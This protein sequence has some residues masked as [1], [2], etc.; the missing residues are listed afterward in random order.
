MKICQ[1]LRSSLALLLVLAS[2][3]GMVPAVFAT[4]DRRQIT[5]YAD[6]LVAQM[7]QEEMFEMYGNE[8]DTFTDPNLNIPEIDELLG[9]EEERE[10]VYVDEGDSSDKGETKDNMGTSYVFLDFKVGS[11]SR[12]FNWQTNSTATA[13]TDSI[14]TARDKQYFAQNPQGILSTYIKGTNACIYMPIE[15][16][17]NGL[18]RLKSYV[19]KSGDIVQI[20]VWSVRQG[21]NHGFKSGGTGSFNSRIDLR[22]SEDNTVFKS[23]GTSTI[24][25]V[26]GSQIVSH[27][28]TNNQVGKTLYGIRWYPVFDTAL[29]G[30]NSNGVLFDVDYMYVGPEKYKPVSVQFLNTDGTNLSAGYVGYNTKAP[31]WNHGKADSES[32]NQQTIWGWAVHQEINGVWTD[33]KKFITDPTTFV[34]TKN[35][36][37]KLTSVTVLKDDLSGELTQVYDNGASDSDDKYKLTVNAIDLNK[38]NLSRYGSPVDVSIVVDRSSSMANLTSTKKFTDKASMTTYL[39]SLDK[40]KY[41][42]YY[43]ASVWRKDYDMGG[44]TYFGWPAFMYHMPM[45]YYR[46]AWQCQVVQ[47]DC[48]CN[49]GVHRSFGVYQFNNTLKQCSHVKWVSMSAAYDLYAK[50]CK[51]EGCTVSKVPFEIGPSRLGRTQYAIESFLQKLYNSTPNLKPGQN[52]TVSLVSFGSSVYIKGYPYSNLNGAYKTSNTVTTASLAKKSIDHTTY[53]TVLECLRD[54]YLN[55]ATRTDA[56][57]QVLSGEISAIEK[58]AGKTATTVNKTDYCPANSSGRKRVVILLTDGVPTTQSEFEDNIFNTTY[59]NDAIDAARRVKNNSYTSMYVIGFMPGLNASKRFDSTANKTDEQKANNFLNLLSSHYKGAT[60]MTSSGSANTDKKEYYFSDTGAGSD[61]AGHFTSI[62]NNSAPSMTT[63]GYTGEA[64]LWLYEEFGREWKPD[65]EDYIKIYAAPYQ[66][67]NKFGSKILIGQHQ[68]T[69]T[70][71]QRIDGKGYIL[72]IDPLTNQSFSVTLQ[73]TD[74]KQSFLRETNLNTDYKATKIDGTALNLKKGYKVY[75][76]IPLEVDRNNTLGGNNIPLTK[77]TSGCY[78]ANGASDT[79][80]GGKL[81][82]YEVPNANVY[83]SVGAEAYDYF[84]NLEEYI[85]LMKSTSTTKLKDTMERMARLPETFRVVNDQKL[86]NLDYVSFDIQLKKSDGTELYHMAAAQKAVALSSN[87]YNLKDSLV[88]LATDQRFTLIATLDNATNNVD[89][90]KRP[91]YPDVKATLYPTYYVP[92]FAVVDFDGNINVN[93]GLESDATKLKNVSGGTFDTADKTMEYTFNNKLL[94][95]DNSLITYTYEATNA[96]LDVTT[97]KPVESKTVSRTLHIIPANVVNYDDTFLSFAGAGQVTNQDVTFVGKDGKTEKIRT[98]IANRVA[99]NTVGTFTAIDQTFDNT[100]PHGYDSAY[101]TTGNFHNSYM[102]ATVKADVVTTD[103]DGDVIKRVSDSTAQAE[104]TFRGTGFEIVSR[105][106]TD[107]GVLIAEVYSGNTLK[108]SILCNTYFSQGNFNQV[109]VIRWDGD[110]GT[111]K[112]K[113]TA[114]YHPAF[115]LRG[116]K[117]ALTTEEVRDILGY[118]DSV[119]FTYIPSKSE[120]ETRAL[121]SSYNVYVDGIRIFNPAASNT[122][123][124]YIYA[125]AGEKVSETGNLR[126]QILDSSN[127][128]GGKADGMLYMADISKTSDSDDTLSSEEYGF[129]LLMDDKLNVEVVELT[130]NGVKQKRIYYLDTNNNRIKDPATGYEFWSMK[131]KGF[132]GYF[133]Y[134]PKP[135]ADKPYLTLSRDYVRGILGDNGHFYHSAYKSY[136][137]KYEIFLQKGHGVAFT[138][139]GSN[140]FL[141]LR[142]ANG[143]ACR[144]QVWNGTAWEDYK[145]PTGKTSLTNLTS[146]TEMFYDFSKYKGSVIIKNVGSGI[147]S[148]VHARTDSAS[149]GIVVD[150]AVAIEAAKAFEPAEER[151][152]LDTLKLSHSLNLQSNISVNYILPKT[153]LEG[154]DHY[155][156]TCEVGGT[157]YYPTAEEKGDYLYFTLDGLT[158]AQMNDNIRGELLAYK[159]D[160]IFVSPADDYSIAQYAYTMLNK[161]NVSSAI[162]TLCANLLRYGSATQVYKNYATDALADEELS[163]VHRELLTDLGAVT[164]RDNY[165]LLGD[166]EAPSVTWYGKTLSLDNTV[167]VKLVVNASDFDGEGNELCLR[168]SYVGAD[169]Q[170]K[171]VVLTTPELYNAEKKLYLFTLDCLEAAE[172]R[173]VLTMA[174]YHGDTQV[175]QTMTYS[176]DTYGIGKSGAL[177]EVCKA[178]FAYA[179]AAKAVFAN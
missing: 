62:W 100:T 166:V 118:D 132:A 161:D 52:H 20:G 135:T 71:Q 13:A 38:L 66:G 93:M 107:S 85:N 82:D 148:L 24:N 152:T 130:E 54:T 99:W 39:D 42:G 153:A 4:N 2:L 41:P 8:N 150:Q 170:Q 73:W 50:L 172:L 129:P 83:C 144:V 133:Y 151:I 146:A 17:K 162:K 44:Y 49:G 15:T 68:I 45:R 6:D 158:A 110:F 18:N 11:A 147:L 25:K 90:F 173:T 80:K 86:S 143:G 156:L 36:R 43:F 142:S 32:G 69:S 48:D 163:Y 26:A 123:T 33:M 94:N 177:L 176:A 29:T 89:S 175:S 46:G 98:E 160:E 75:M 74:A 149:K 84:I 40:T 131:Y 79:A 138:A 59:A 104:F 113:L 51:A 109:P 102:K 115:A 145:D 27:K 116:T 117:N 125:L 168:V 141:S 159:G 67:S 92:K 171:N 10:F 167:A 34:C 23:T 127:W 78:K 70:S 12:N 111:Y 112:V 119:D 122:V 91:P 164:F 134:N 9:E 16:H 31:A 105:A 103:A 178:L 72:H 21:T 120:G 106:T 154:F 5:V 63:A 14:F 64:S 19:L 60:N 121:A 35:T 157:I 58:S 137:P 88:S 95:A 7:D 97:N 155:S 169:G 3:L 56:A 1:L 77:N 76:E 47:D 140:V 101:A 136:G 55:G 87:V 114:Y 37:L 108:A 53:E 174:V 22:T 139:N 57:L 165:A 61:I 65:P 124:N 30:D 28:I 96:P 128:T 179:D 126:D 81:S